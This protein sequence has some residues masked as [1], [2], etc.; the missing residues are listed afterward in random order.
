MDGWKTF[1]FPFWELPIYFPGDRLALGSVHLK[2]CPWGY[3]ITKHLEVRISYMGRVVA[4]KILQKSHAFFINPKSN[5]MFEYFQ[6]H[7]SFNKRHWHL[8]LGKCLDKKDVR[9]TVW[10]ARCS[11]TKQPLLR[12]RS[13]NATMVA[14]HSL[15]L[16]AM[17]KRSMSLSTC[18]VSQGKK[19]EHP[20]PQ[21]KGWLGRF[22]IPKQG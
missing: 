10:K 3:W 17:T 19:K 18:Q 13:S 1:S 11:L 15:A 2:I 4:F 12:K 5:D 8:L 20:I 21:Y 9:E 16:L 14:H 7:I 22:I 6:I